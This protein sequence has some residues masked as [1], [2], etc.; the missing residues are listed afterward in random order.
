MDKSDQFSVL[1]V[2]KFW[3]K[4]KAK[5]LFNK[6]YLIMVLQNFNVRWYD[7]TSW[8]IVL[9]CLSVGCLKSWF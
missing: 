2:L 3:W 1:K 4:N 8:E 6:K 5:N 9:D 7:T